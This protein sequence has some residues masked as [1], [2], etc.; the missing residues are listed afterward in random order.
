M[1]EAH[2]LLR[3]HHLLRPQEPALHLAEEDEGVEELPAYGWL[4]GVR[5]RASMLEFRLK[6]G[7]CQALGYPWLFKVDFE[8]S[9][10]IVLNFTTWVVTLAGRNLREL[11]GMIQRHRVVWVQESDALRD[12]ASDKATVIT[13]ITLAQQ[14]P[15]EE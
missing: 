1:S 13:S 5:D 14:K 10:G 6:T 7:N 15:Q 2:E 11:Y 9:K 12:T 4:R 3:K 8:P